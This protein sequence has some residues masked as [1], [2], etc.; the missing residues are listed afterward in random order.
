MHV[1]NTYLRMTFTMN[2]ARETYVKA[3]TQIC[4]LQSRCRGGRLYNTP[5]CTHESIPPC[6]QF[7]PRSNHAFRFKTNL[8]VIQTTT[9]VFKVGAVLV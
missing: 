5:V 4:N 2:K 1:S 8:A 9:H 7:L 3:R 6:Y